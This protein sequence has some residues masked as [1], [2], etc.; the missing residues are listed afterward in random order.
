MIGV[1]AL[2]R[3]AAVF[4]RFP[5][6]DFRGAGEQLAPHDD[7]RVGAPVVVPRLLSEAALPLPSSGPYLQIA[8]IDLSGQDRWLCGAIATQLAA[9]GQSLFAFT[10]STQSSTRARRD[11]TN[12]RLGRGKLRLPFAARRRGG[13]W[14]ISEDVCKCHSDLLG[15]LGPV[16]K[17]IDAACV[18]DANQFNNA[19]EGCDGVVLVRRSATTAAY[20]LLVAEQ[21]TAGAVHVP[22]VRVVA[23]DGQGAVAS[24]A[25][26]VRPVHADGQ[27][28]QLAV[29]DGGV[30]S[31]VVL[32]AAEELAIHF[33]WRDAVSERLGRS[34]SEELQHAVGDVVWRLIH[35]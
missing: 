9:D 7:G 24:V 11:A 16:V 14:Q 27:R 35:A 8:V 29:I 13:V 15:S 33:G 28:P 23:G 30:A 26:D 20:S 31:G 2:R 25:H 10:A 1:T 3:L 17:W 18:E 6:N 4:V 32:G 19:L 21:L 22:V 34:A 5:D 12:V